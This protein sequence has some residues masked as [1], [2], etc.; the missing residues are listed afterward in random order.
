MKLEYEEETTTTIQG[1]NVNLPQTKKDIKPHLAQI[2]DACNNSTK[3]LL[4]SAKTVTFLTG[5][6]AW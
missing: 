4:E 3:L 1:V 5:A 6:L 2:I